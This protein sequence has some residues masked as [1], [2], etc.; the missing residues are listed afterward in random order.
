VVVFRIDADQ[1]VDNR[2]GDLV[3]SDKGKEMQLKVWNEIV[4]SLSAKVPTVL[5]IVGKGL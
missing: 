5:E 1:L 3:T 2:A 4:E